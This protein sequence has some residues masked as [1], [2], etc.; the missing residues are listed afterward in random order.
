MCNCKKAFRWRRLN[1]F[2]PQ[3]ARVAGPAD[4]TIC[5]TASGRQSWNPT[6]DAIY[7]IAFPCW[8][9][10]ASFTHKSQYI[11]KSLF[12]LENLLLLLPVSLHWRSSRLSLCLPN[13]SPSLSSVFAL[14]QHGY[15]TL[16]CRLRIRMRRCGRIRPIRRDQCR[17]RLG[18]PGTP[19][20]YVQN[21]VPCTS[22]NNKTAVG[23]ACPDAS[24]MTVCAVNSDG[25]VECAA[26]CCYNNGLFGRQ[27][28]TGCL[29]CGLG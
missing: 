1:T 13:C 19:N 11:K 12:H 24:S 5:D 8:E 10:T 25:S 22:G 14:S 7:A 2:I 27:S 20:R 28:P 4:A 18:Y 9:I 16:R 15:E 3:E 29:I 26:V 23:S 17:P 21:S 6:R